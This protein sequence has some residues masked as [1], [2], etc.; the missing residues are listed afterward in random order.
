MR[1]PRKRVGLL[2]AAGTL[3]GMAAGC[4]TSARGGPPEGGRSTGPSPSLP[5]AVR[6]V[7]SVSPLS[8]PASGSGSAA[9]AAAEQRFALALTTAAYRAAPPDADVLLSPFSAAADLAMLQ[10]GSGPRTAPEIA[11]TLREESLTSAQL[12]AG[13]RTLDTAMRSAQS[14]GELQIATSLW[15]SRRLHVEPGFLDAVALGFGNDTYQVD[16]TSPAATQSINAWVREETAGRIRQLFRAGDLDPVTEVVLAEALH[17]HA[18][19]AAG[20]SISNGSVENRPF[21]TAAGATVSVPTVVAGNV[22]LETASGSGYEAAEIPYSNGRFAALLVE[23]DAGTL[24]RFLPSL[25]T[26]ALASI[27]AALRPALLNLSMPELHESVDAKLDGVLGPMGLAPLYAGADFSPM[28][29][30]AGAVNQALGIVKQAA[31]LGVTQWGTDAAAATGASVVPTA[32]T[33]RSVTIDHPYL[34]LLRD[35]VTGAILFS[36]VVANPAG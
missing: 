21:T 8:G 20:T 33:S 27:V 13:W 11:A 25:T 6:L 17:F 9:V 36:S 31:T 10:L 7:A 16:F 18:A 3:A 1:T 5:G 32:A 35:T 12:V 28:L 2:L 29:G 30:P 4:G 15:L 23:P 14:P 26:G 22:S 34:F 19:W 24:A